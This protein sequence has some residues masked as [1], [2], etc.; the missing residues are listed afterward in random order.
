MAITFIERN[1][2][3][4]NAA[5]IT[6]TNIPQTGKHLLL[7]ISC[8]TAYTGAVNDVLYLEFN[9]NTSSVYTS[10]RLRGT[11]TTVAFNENPGEWPL[12]GPFVNGNTSTSDAFG[13]STI[14]IGNY[15]SSQRKTISID[16]VQ[17]TNATA[18]NMM[19]NAGEFNSTSA[20]TSIKITSLQGSNLLANTSVTLYSIS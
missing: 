5:N 3:G 6:F 17:E 20:I 4:S 13:V 16:A 10:R 12:Y 8:R 14:Y 11:G 9:S 18:A 1:V 7:S 19:I 15:T 2:L